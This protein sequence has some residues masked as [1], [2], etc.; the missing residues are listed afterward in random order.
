M[1]D[2][3]HQFLLAVQ[4]NW[5]GVYN[6]VAP[7]PVTNKELTKHMASALGKPLILPNVPGFVLKLMLGEMASLVLG[8][9]RI[10]NAKA[11]Q[12]GMT[13]LFPTAQEAVNDLLAG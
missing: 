5:E 13:Y 8:G 2:L 11:E 9:S 3:C 4:Q 10:S 12:A 7:N 1:A 6:A